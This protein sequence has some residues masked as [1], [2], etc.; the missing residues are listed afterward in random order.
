MSKI[1]QNK[2]KKRLAILRA[3][4]EQFLTAGYGLANMDCIA[5][6]AQ[7][8]KQTVY[9][10]YASKEVLFKATLEH[11][12]S[13]FDDKATQYLSLDDNHAALLG[14]AIEYISF[15][16]S[17]EHIATFRLLVA[18]SGNSPEIITNFF[19]V[20]PDDV[21]RVLIEFFQ[22]RFNVTDIETTVELWLGMLLNHR[23]KVLMGMTSPTR[24]EI[25][26]YAEAATAF[27]LRAVE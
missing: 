25:E 7:M 11:M 3:A 14:F 24:S 19:S 20:G 4:Q 1:E 13:Q 26:H 12:G 8:T 9:R 10:Y 18:E 21:Q 2:Q 27:L 22:Q 6:E 23:N 17:D 15:H 5:S 16:L